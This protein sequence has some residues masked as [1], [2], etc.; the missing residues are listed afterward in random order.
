MAFSDM[1]LG[2]VGGPTGLPF[3]DIKA[4]LRHFPEPDA[5]R[6]RAAR[7]M[8]TERAGGIRHGS[9][10]PLAAWLASW[11]SI[12]RPAVERMQLALFVSR[13]DPLADIDGN[14]NAVAFL[15]AISSGA[16]LASQ[17]C[18]RQGA[19]LKLYDLALEAATPDPRLEPVMSEQE[20]AA[21]MAFGMEATAGG[22]DVLA[23]S[24]A[25][26]GGEAAAL[27]LLTLLSEEGPGQLL[28]RLSG[29]AQAAVAAIVARHREAASDPFEVLR[30]VGSRDLA[31]LVGAILA[32]RTQRL[33]VILD[34]LGAL[35]AAAVLA[36]A[37]GEN[38]G[39]CL[40]G[41]TDDAGLRQLAVS[42]GVND[43][44]ALPGAE[45]EGVGALLALPA[46]RA[47]ADALAI[48]EV[49]AHADGCA[50]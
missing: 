43:F 45:G 41:A 10:I 29:A 21:T 2:E 11:K 3:D 12:T 4:V 30:R 5:C 14:S 7:R 19:G 1:R 31:A 44:Q 28:A 24:R 22:I 17:L 18:L 8:L 32:A 33:P 49:S 42:L 16:H 35:A 6:G 36:R 34:G 13:I 39:H 48:A 38:L 46:L 25:G 37:G 50:G 9:L 23:L 20:C 47:A 40:L 15:N 26:E 27:A